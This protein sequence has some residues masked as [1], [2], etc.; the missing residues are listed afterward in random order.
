[1]SSIKVYE[2]K[3]NFKALLLMLSIFSIL[4]AAMFGLTGCDEEQ[5][6]KVDNI[7]GS[8]KP[9]TE[10]G[11][12]ILESPAGAVIP[13]QYIGMTKAA[14]TLALIAAATWFKIR[15][16]QAVSR[17]AKTSDKLDITKQT[18]SCVVQAVESPNDTKP[19]V[20]K[21]LQESY[22]YPDGKRIIDEAKNG[23]YCTET[24]KNA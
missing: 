5:L 24:D 7:V 16:K 11:E 13:P 10:V 4:C 1:M 3:F 22:I 6:Q 9:I 12:Q 20:K 2:K 14:G 21:M 8:V 23:Y 17:E 18:L 19:T 15:E